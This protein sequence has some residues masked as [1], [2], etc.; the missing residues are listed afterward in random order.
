VVPSS[1]RPSSCVLLSS[2][3]DIIW[4]VSW[5]LLRPAGCASAVGFIGLTDHWVGAAVLRP[6]DRSYT[7]TVRI[8]LPSGEAAAIL[9]DAI[10][11]DDELQPTKITRTISADGSDLV[12]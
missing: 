11:V 7:S 3:H 1:S 6:M 8:R 10:E 4:S 9:R 5:S 12:V 2:H